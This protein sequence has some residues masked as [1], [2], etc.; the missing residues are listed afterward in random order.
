M[1]NQMFGILIFFF[2]VIQ[3]MFQIIPVFVVQR[4][5]YEARE[6]Q[7]KTYAW[8]AFVLSNIVVEFAWNSVSPIPFP[9]FV[10]TTRPTK[11]NLDRHQL[12]AIFCFLVW[13]Y[14]LG[15]Y[16]NAQYT[17][18]IHS[19]STLAFL[20][21][22]VLFLFCSSMAHMLI[23]G[24][25]SD[26]MASALANILSIM[27]YA[28]CG[29]LAGP[30]ALPGFWIFMYRVNPFTYVTAGLLSTSL[31]NAP[32]HC[33]ENEYLAFSAPENMT[34]GEFMT[35]YMQA[36]GGEV[37]NPSARGSEQCQFCSVTWTNDYLKG[38]SIDFEQRWRDFGLVW[39]YVVFNVCAAVFLYWLCR[40]P[41]G[42][43]KK[44]AKAN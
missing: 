23:A 28:F 37:V 19:R 10:Q 14:P 16:Q 11:L 22:W 34:C 13:F 21:V 7:S 24:V 5:L 15:V 6:R 30:D 43:K 32:M 17:S 20:I 9:S 31:G 42:K 3:L 44:K 12:M 29:I 25:S 26:E 35:P 27:L 4:T 18:T 38:V 2:V 40:V 33:A 39:A 36:N 8:Q 1:Q 41:K